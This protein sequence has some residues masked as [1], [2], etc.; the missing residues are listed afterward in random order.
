[1]ATLGDR[2]RREREARG[3]TLGEVAQRLGLKG[4]STYSNWE[5]NNREPDAHML[6]KLA[7]LYEV[8]VDYLVGMESKKKEMPGYLPKHK[9]EFIVREMVEKY[10]IDLTDPDKKQKLEALVKLVF[11]DQK[12]GNKSV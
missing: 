2:L 3:W 8:P 4:H 12:G 6:V 1:M 11:D 7:E 10:H 5:Y 9:S